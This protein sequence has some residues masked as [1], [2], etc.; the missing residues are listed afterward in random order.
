MC[1]FCL[2]GSNEFH[3]TPGSTRPSQLHKMYHSRHMAKNSWWWVERLPE[4]CRVVTPTKL[5]FS[6]SVVFI[7]KESENDHSAAYVLMNTV[8]VIKT[9]WNNDT[10]YLLSSMPV[11]FSAWLSISLE[12]HSLNSSCESKRVGM[13][14]CS[15]AHSSAMLFWMGVPL[16]SNLFRQLNPKRSFQ[17]TLKY[18]VQSHIIMSDLRLLQQC[19]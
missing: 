13:M 5:E 6:A 15:R 11:L 9:Q 2:F 18:K 17:R 1:I 14:K 7:H 8:P 19:C 12:N 10:S 3:P 4:T 16:S